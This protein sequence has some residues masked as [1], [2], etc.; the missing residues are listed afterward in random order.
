MQRRLGPGVWTAGKMLAFQFLH[1]IN[2][3]DLAEAELWAL[4]CRDQGRP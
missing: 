2:A 3:A 1:R 4:G